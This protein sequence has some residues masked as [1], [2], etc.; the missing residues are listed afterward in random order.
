MCYDDY[1]MRLI[2]IW[3]QIPVL[4]LLFIFMQWL[5]DTPNDVSDRKFQHWCQNVRVWVV[6]NQIAKASGL[7]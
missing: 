6:P 1:D 3:T 4:A 7:T 2:Q 5:S